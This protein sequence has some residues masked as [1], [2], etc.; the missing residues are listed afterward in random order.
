M[1]SKQLRRLL[2]SLS[3]ALLVVLSLV[4]L[5][6]FFLLLRH[7]G[8]VEND[9][10]VLPGYLLLSGIEW[11]AID[12]RQTL[13][14]F[15]NGI[16][17]E[18]AGVVVFIKPH[19]GSGVGLADEND[20]VVEVD[21]PAGKGMGT[22]SGLPCGIAIM[23]TE[24]LLQGLIVVAATVSLLLLRGHHHIATACGVFTA[25]DEHPCLHAC[26]VSGQL[27]AVFTLQAFLLQLLHH[28]LRGEGQRQVYELGVSLGYG[29]QYEQP[30]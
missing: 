4:V 13:A 8:L 10:F 5:A 24:P 20:V 23:L 2:H 21:E 29:W 18:V 16:I 12:Q 1:F 22:D 15:E 11:N 14:A 19:L 26:Y 6:G 30:A 27:T 3:S 7:I 17:V 9:G 28:L 25:L